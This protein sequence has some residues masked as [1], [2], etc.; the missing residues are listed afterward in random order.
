MAISIKVSLKRDSG[1]V[2]DIDMEIKDR[3]VTALYGPSGSGKSTILRLIAGLERGS[4]K[5]TIEITADAS[6]WQSDDLFMAPEKRGVGMVFQ[7]PQLFPHLTVEGNLAFARK[8]RHSRQNLDTNQLLKWLDVT[9]LLN[10]NVAELSGGEAQRVAMARVILNGAKYILMDEPLGSIDNAAR[11]RILPYLERLHHELEVPI[12]YVS[13][14]FEEVSYLADD[15]FVLDNGKIQ[16]RGSLMALSSDIELASGQGDSAATVIQCRVKEHD[17]EFG[18]TELDFE[19]ASIFVN[20]GNYSV[21]DS[22][23]DPVR[24]R[25]PARDVSVATTKPE[26]SSILNILKMQ[27]VSIERS[28]GSGLLLRLCRND[29]FLLARIT[30][31][32][33]DHLGLEINQFVYAQIK[34]IALLHDNSPS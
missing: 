34:S 21:G 2:L 27:I 8:H 32:S 23:G 10:K 31:K 33:L 30:R 18:L 14:S 28:A 6:T 5:D 3:G 19:G 13:H 15:L 4:A 22:A 24:V 1:F 16:C 26:N 12:V 20:T 25:V 11:H 17:P 29:Q 9:Q 7:R